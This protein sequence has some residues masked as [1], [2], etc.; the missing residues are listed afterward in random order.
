MA[1]ESYLIEEVQSLV[2]DCEDLNQW[3]E[4]VDK[5]GLEGQ[6]KRVSVE[7]K[8]PIPFPAMTQGQVNVYKT[9]CPRDASIEL[10]S[11][12]TIP[13]RVLSLI[14]LCKQEGYFKQMEVWSD[15]M[16]PD[17][18]LVGWVGNKYTGS[19]HLIARWGDELRSYPELEQIAR[20]RLLKQ[21]GATLSSELNNLPHRVELFISGRETSLAIY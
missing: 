14:A 21:R 2:T 4:M 3:Q 1:V 10:Y 20:E 13:L 18:V 17:P 9:L 12:G 15:E 8:S 6:K 19:P 11:G 5:F 7:G 16:T